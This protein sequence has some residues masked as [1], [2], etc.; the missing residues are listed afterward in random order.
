MGK[1]LSSNSLTPSKYDLLG[2]ETHRVFNHCMHA[3]SLIPTILKQIPWLRI[4]IS[5]PLTILLNATS[6]LPSLA[7][8]MTPFITRII[9]LHKILPKI[10]K[11][12]VYVDHLRCFNLMNLNY[13]CFL[14]SKEVKK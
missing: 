9:G 4:V 13:N 3:L 7:L 12:V 8:N 1:K 10:V 5:I 14:F 11:F 2:I 6:T